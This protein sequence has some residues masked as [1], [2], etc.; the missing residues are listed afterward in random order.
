MVPDS[1]FNIL[2]T[3]K[4][5]ESFISISPIK[6]FSQ[7]I[8]FM[9]IFKNICCKSTTLVSELPSPSALHREIIFGCDEALLPMRSQPGLETEHT[10]H[11][12]VW[13]SGTGH[14][15][16]CGA[17]GGGG[18]TNQIFKPHPDT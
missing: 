7:A 17:A 8:I 13:G 15:S 6:T 11:R 10:C 16:E 12:L 14:H 3:F 5:N 9:V 4:S 18:V 1:E 2:Q